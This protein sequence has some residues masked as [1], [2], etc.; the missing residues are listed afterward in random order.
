MLFQ[1]IVD[2]VSMGA[3]YGTLALALVLVFRSMKL[4]NFAQGEMALLATFIGWQLTAWGVPV[5]GAFAGAIV[6]GFVIGAL[7]ERVVIRRVEG[8]DHLTIVILTLGLFLLINSIIG[9]T[10]GH[11]TKDFPSLFGNHVFSIGSVRVTSQAI[12]T[13][14]LVLLM[15]A[16]LSLF[17]RKTKLGLAINAASGNPESASLLGIN[18]R[19]TFTLSWGLASGLGA[20]SGVLVAPVLFLQPHMMFTLLVYAF[21]AAVLGGLDSPRGAVLG[22]VILGVSE[23]LVTTYVP[24]VAADAKIAV[25]MLIIFAVLLVRPQGLMGSPIVGRV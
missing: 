24:Y 8:K 21:A 19:R 12:G 20:A 3:V 18:V 17:F 25:A 22:G 16:A 11:V 13:V 7:I 2:G 1:Q 23:N 10:W 15:A 14:A 9:L 4:V 6:A 5:V